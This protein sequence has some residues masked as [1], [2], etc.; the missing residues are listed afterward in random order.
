[1][2]GQLDVRLSGV[3]AEL[4][5][6]KETIM[7][8]VLRRARLGLEVLE[9]R[10]VPAYAIGDLGAIT[11]AAINNAGIIAGAA[12]GHAAIQQNG[13]VID[14]G[15]LGGAGSR[16]TAINAAG[17]VVGA[18]GLP[19]GTSHA[20]VVTPQ[21]TDGDGVPDLWFRDADANGVNDLMLDLGTLGGPNS[22]ANGINNL[23]QVV[24]RADTSAAA[25]SYRAFL[26]D[27]AGGMRNLYNLGVG[28]TA[29][30]ANAIND[31]GQI[32][33]T[34]YWLNAG[35]ILN[36][37]RGFRWDPAA[38]VTTLGSLP[39]TPIFGYGSL[40]TSKATGIDQNGDVV[41]VAGVIYTTGVV[42][43]WYYPNDAFLW[44][45]GSMTPLGFST[46]RDYKQDYDVSI[47]NSGEI[48]GAKFFWQAGTHGNL[49][50]LLDPSQSWT[51]T[52]SADINDAGQ[53]VGQGTHNGV[54]PSSFT[55]TAGT[56]PVPSLTIGNVSVNEGDTGTVTA[57]FV[58]TR[59][60]PTDQS[61]TV[62]FATADGTATTGKDY[63]ATSGT[64]TF[65]PG[66]T[67]KTV[68]VDVL[69]DL[70]D[71]YDETFTV[72]LSNAS[73]VFLASNQAV[74]TILDNDPPPQLTISDVTKLE[75]KAKQ[76]T[77][78]VFTVSLSAASEKTVSVDY[79]TADGTA[80]SSGRQA[81][82]Y[83]ASG[84][85][86]F[87]P[88]QTTATITIYVIG[89]S[90]REANETFLVNLLNPVNSFL[91]HGQG[92]GTILN[93]D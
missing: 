89:D 44:Q 35:T 9:D 38:G 31:H 72:R 46:Q 80:T 6:G 86:Q 61:A 64:L 73:G 71:E 81:D 40:G 18:A 93:D 52:S 49:N 62:D 57:V 22:V 85:L 34:E 92:L 45:S 43:R 90:R 23:G 63:V 91:L 47:N 50:D 66:E 3:R 77:A 87:N 67:T 39:Y 1:L 32:A 65:A 74:G 8:R 69:G 19:G 60:G 7:R 76:L 88:G 21:D 26:W 28:G 24:G 15:T 14:L 79:L 5:P 51:I 48:V 11:P 70:V 2:N 33:G 29:S 30:E 78:F 12:S 13:V 53:V 68:L 17:Q 37:I 83:A 82:Y 16:A 42:A 75:G 84:T 54:T 10:R 27:S 59:S 36:N 25:G 41:G 55:L 4:H 20:F 56:A 58:V